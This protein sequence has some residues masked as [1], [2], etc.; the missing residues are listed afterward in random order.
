MKSGR[1]LSKVVRFL[2]R[3]E[4]S[5]RFES[6]LSAHVDPAVEEFDLDWEDFGAILGNHWQL[7]HWGCAFADLLTRRFEPDGANLVE[8]FLTR[9]GWNEAAPAKA[10]LRALQGSVPG[11]YEVSDI[12]PGVSFRARDLLRGGEPILVSEASASRTLK[13]WDR[14]AVRIVALGGKTILSGGLLP[15]SLEA[16]EALEDELRLAT[17]R[18]GRSKLVLD[19]EALRMHAPLFTIAWLF[20]VLPEALGEVMPEVRNSEG[21]ELLFHRIRFPIPDGASPA[22]TAARLDGMMELR[23]ETDRFWNWRG[24]P[25]D[26]E[27]AGRSRTGG[28]SLTSTLDDG[29]VVLGTLELGDRALELLVNSAPRAA[30]GLALLQPRLGD[31][32][33]LP[34][35]EIQTLQQLQAAGAKSPPPPLDIPPDE[36]RALVHDMLDKQYRAT[37]DEPVG[38][39]D[40]KTP[41]QA[42]R[43]KAGR[44][45]VVAWLKYLENRTA[46]VLDPDDPM[47]S[48][49]FG[50][51][52]ETL[53]VRDLRS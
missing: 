9:R 47:A 6:V 29:G 21:D 44:Q 42:V 37:L 36:V 39:L 25:P 50:W 46:Y 35:T 15:Y 23:K 7:T 40:G 1:D 49:N 51:M 14:I 48:Y 16:S 20:D 18:R 24:E 17:G 30:R 27:A 3:P 32:V 31:L 10:Y 22:A 2:S 26:P 13:P 52:W 11:L 33:G 5:D 19:D 34:L 53:G 28:L 38:M 4:W 41:R 45:K 8:D 12:L 43:S